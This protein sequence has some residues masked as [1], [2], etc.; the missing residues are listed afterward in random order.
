MKFLNG[1]KKAFGPLVL[2]GAM[3]AGGTEQ[4]FAVAGAAIDVTDVT[5]TITA[6]GASITGIGAVILGIVTLI[7]AISWV[8]RPIH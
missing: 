5:G 4:A 3:V 8:R 2:L 6:Q 7:A 1:L